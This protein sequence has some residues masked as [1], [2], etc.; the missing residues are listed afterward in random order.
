[1]NIFMLF[2]TISPP[3]TIDYGSSHTTNKN[4]SPDDHPKKDEKSN[5]NSPTQRKTVTIVEPIES[6][7]S[8]GV[9]KETDPLLT[10]EKN[11]Q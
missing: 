5:S 3:T 2:Q 8:T 10:S 11:D 7:P 4:N 1:M 6:K 9:S